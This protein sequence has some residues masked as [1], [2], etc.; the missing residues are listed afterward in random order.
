MAATRDKSL[1]STSKQVQFPSLQTSMGQST[2]VKSSDQSVKSSQKANQQAL[3]SAK[4]KKQLTK[5]QTSG[6]AINGDK[7]EILLNSILQD[8]QQQYLRNTV[9][10]AG[11]R[12]R[13]QPEG[14]SLKRDPSGISLARS[15]SNVPKI[16]HTPSK[17][18]NFLM[19]SK[20]LFFAQSESQIIDDNNKEDNLNSQDETNKAFN[21]TSRTSISQERY[22]FT[23]GDSKYKEITELRKII[24]QKDEVI[25]KMKREL[26][27]ID[28]FKIAM[29]KKYSEAD[30][31]EKRI[32]LLKGLFILL[33]LRRSSE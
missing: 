27:D 15:E 31:N 25:E 6:S 8:N 20:S 14:L 11:A 21:K 23:L 19:E 30:F 18:V 26:A 1:N 17:S 24:E 10:A 5:S 16:S 4:L 2:R 28:E 12:A 9:S 32:N 22:R 3:N 13:A 7:I 29:E 33:I